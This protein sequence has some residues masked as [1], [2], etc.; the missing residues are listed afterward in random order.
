[1]A[2]LNKSFLK[3]M[4]LFKLVEYNHSYRKII[5]LVK[6]LGD[7]EANENNSLAI[8]GDTPTSR[9]LVNDFGLALNS[10][11]YSLWCLTYYGVNSFTIEKLRDEFEDINIMVPRLNDLPALGLHDSTISKIMLLISDLRLNQKG[12]LE[13]ELLRIIEE[14]EP[15][16]NI[17]LKT[18]IFNKYYDVDSKMFDSLI[19]SMINR[20]VIVNTISGY[21]IK[22]FSL[23]EYL[24]ESNEEIDSVVMDRCKGRTL[25]DIGIEV[26]LTRERVRQKIAKRIL[27]L[28]VFNKEKEYF[29]IRSLYSFSKKDAEILEFEIPIWNYISLKYNDLSPEK[30]VI[31]YLK[32]NNLCDTEKGRKVFKEYRLL[33]VDNQIVEDDFIDLF[34]RFFNKQKYNSFKVLDIAEDFNNY[35]LKNSISNEDYYISNTNL[36]IICRKLEN[37]GKFLN[38]GAKRFIFFEEDALSSDLIELMREYLSEFDGYGSVLL[39]YN[40]NQKICSYNNIHD[41][42]ELFI[43]MKRLFAKEFKKSIEFIRNPTLAKKGIDKETYIENLL[44]DLNLPCTVEEYLDYIYNTTGLKQVSVQSNFANI[45]TKYKNANG[46]I[47]LDDEYTDEEAQTFKELLADRE[48]IGAKLFDFQVKSVFKNKSNTFLNANTIR[49]FGDYKTNTSIYKD[50]YQ[51]RLEAVQTILKDQDMLLT[52]GEISKFCDIEFLTYRQYDALKDCLALRIGDNRYLNIVARG[53]QERV[54]Q[55]KKDLL[56]I[57]DEEEIYVLNDFINEPLFNR[58]LNQGN[59]YNNILYAFDMREILKFIFTTTDGFSYLSQGDTF[60]FSKALISYESIISHIMNEYES[61]SI[62]EFKEVLY[63]RYRITKSFSN[64]ELSNMGYY[65]PYTS[66]KVYLNEDYYEYEMEEYLNG[67]S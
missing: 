7:D 56:N 48:C 44:L 61:I 64:S 28:P 6:E 45:I 43:V 47:S 22:H 52:E 1:M 38:V 3:N 59:D 24:N 36:A 11:H 21:K 33:V 16:Q 67:N 41:E 37:S 18:I 53:E 40:Q 49:K 55:L 19:D 32:D 13:N 14:N 39:F 15:I 31:D 29:R 62:C 10:D 63:E 23:V 51:S 60:L 26:N 66:E 9:A 20:K 58:L 8:L 5:K 54:K 57:L 42:N 30:N 27:Q 12:A 46:M 35:L 34:V 50:K 25:D 2:E 65:C 17:E 4:K